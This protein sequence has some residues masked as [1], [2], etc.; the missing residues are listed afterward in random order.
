MNWL[1]AIIV[2]AIIGGIIAYANTGK[3]EDAIGGAVAGGMGCGWIIAQIGI[4]VIGL[5][6]VIKVF[7]WLFN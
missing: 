1:I 3:K 6:I 4:A 7:S 5:M 2:C